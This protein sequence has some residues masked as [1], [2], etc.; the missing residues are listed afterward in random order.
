M[1]VSITWLLLAGHTSS[2][3]PNSHGTDDEGSRREILRHGQNEED[4]RGDAQGD[5]VR[6]GDEEA[7]TTPRELDHLG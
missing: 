2:Y 5:G 4:G 7:V 6:G 3:I 1:L